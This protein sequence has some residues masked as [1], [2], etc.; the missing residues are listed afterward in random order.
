[1]DDAALA[2]LEHE[3]MVGANS[4]AG[5]E[6]PGAR[7]ERAGGVALI[8]TGLP[9]RL[10]NQVIVDGDDASADSIAAAVAVARDRGDR[11]VV[12]LRAGT[13]DRHRGLMDSLGLV[14]LSDG[15]W[16][17]GMALHPLPPPGSVRP[18]P[19]HEIRRIVDAA[20]LAD[21][22]G[23]AA[24]GFGMPREWL[25]A[26]MTTRL[27]DEPAATVYVGY[28][29]GVP[30]A[31]GL[32]IRTGR[33]IGV[34]SIATIETARKRGYGAAMTMR[35]VDDGAAGGCDVAILQASDMGQPIYERLGFRT[36]VEYTGWVDPAS[37]E[38]HDEA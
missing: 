18:A 17:P 19:G 32:G 29:D 8:L 25:E 5:G 27:L 7:V 1:M 20:G 3:N 28:T 21:H 13:D 31:T 2:R 6:V 30:V 14:P 4:L 37:L 38:P 34:Y 22:V 11:F 15:V 10:F 12:N 9:L 33:T 24:D 35:V 26:I 16:M 23:A 36:V